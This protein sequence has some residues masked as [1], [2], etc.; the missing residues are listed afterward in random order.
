MSRAEVAAQRSTPAAAIASARHQETSIMPKSNKQQA[1]GEEQTLTAPP[2]SPARDW[3]TMSPWKE[4][5]PGL[6]PAAIMS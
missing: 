5:G 6:N 1:D 4:R 2:T 3:E